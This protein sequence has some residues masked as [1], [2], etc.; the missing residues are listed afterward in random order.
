M[1]L[2]SFNVA[3]DGRRQRALKGLPPEMVLHEGLKDKPAL[4]RAAAK[5]AD[6]AD[7][8]RALKV[9]TNIKEVSQADTALVS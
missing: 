1:L 9:I 7:P 3:C 2:A 8:D 6:P 5:N 4:A